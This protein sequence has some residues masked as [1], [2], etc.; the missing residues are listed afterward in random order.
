LEPTTE[1]PEQFA[2]D[3]L[4]KPFKP[5]ALLLKVHKLLQPPPG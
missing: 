1:K 2:N 5:E 3:Y 4:P